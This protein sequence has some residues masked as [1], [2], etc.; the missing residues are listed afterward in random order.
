MDAHSEHER[1]DRRSLQTSNLSDCFHPHC[2][3]DH[4][5]PLCN[6][7]SPAASLS[8]Y[9]LL[10]SKLS[11]TRIAGATIPGRFSQTDQSN[12]PNNKTLSQL[13]DH[14]QVLHRSTHRACIQPFAKIRLC[15]EV[16]KERGGLVGAEMVLLRVPS[17]PFQR[18]Q[19][20]FR[21]WRTLEVR[22]HRGGSSGSP[23]LGAQEPRK[24]PHSNLSREDPPPC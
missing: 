16:K 20:T 8:V 3:R 22:S 13:D 14:R 21:E 12:H 10:A 1:A 19:L 24:K 4:S 6:R 9:R 15:G 11:S 7:L 23:F 18:N 5:R 17:I 2:G